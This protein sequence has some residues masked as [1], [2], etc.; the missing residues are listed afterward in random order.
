MRIVVL[1][2]FYL[3]VEFTYSTVLTKFIN[4]VEFH[5]KA[6]TN[7]KFNVLSWKNNKRS[8]LCNVLNG[9]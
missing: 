2:M 8:K 6:F 1:E 9:T 3:I 7:V 4:N 5:A